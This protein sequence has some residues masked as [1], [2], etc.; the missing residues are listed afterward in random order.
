MV[1]LQLP[2]TE[3]TKL[4][5]QQCLNMNMAL[6]I[7]IINIKKN[8]KGEDDS[9]SYQIDEI[10]P[11]G[12]RNF[13]DFG[14]PA[15]A[16]SI[17][18]FPIL[19]FRVEVATYDNAAALALWRSVFARASQVILTGIPPRIYLRRVCPLILMIQIMVV[20]LSEWIASLKLFLESQ[21]FQEHMTKFLH[22][23]H[24]KQQFVLAKRFG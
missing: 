19:L 3:P 15:P 13:V 24:E 17:P 5:P 23:T 11:M 4:M 10:T 8:D 18:Y 6:F 1:G 2:K 12:R 21:V 14:W 16:Y 20:Q 9:A 7:D 22:P